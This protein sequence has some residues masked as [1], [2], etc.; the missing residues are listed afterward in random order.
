MT[1]KGMLF[2]LILWKK[3][4]RLPLFQAYSSFLLKIDFLI[5]KQPHTPDFQIGLSSVSCFLSPIVLFYFSQSTPCLLCDMI[6][7]LVDQFHSFCHNRI[8]P[9][10]VVSILQ[11]YTF[12]PVWEYWLKYSDKC[13][14]KQIYSIIITCLLYFLSTTGTFH[15]CMAKQIAITWVFSTLVLSF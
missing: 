3:I 10:G 2:L 15:G 13:E 14:E 7:L 9:G 5:P 8:G 11:M 6:H 12:Y 1:L 4:M